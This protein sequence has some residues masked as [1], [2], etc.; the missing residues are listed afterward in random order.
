[1]LCFDLFNRF[2]NV[3]VLFLPFVTFGDLLAIGLELR[4]MFLVV[5]ASNE[6]TIQSSCN[7][8]MN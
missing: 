6:A 8:D 7:R 3:C 1:M 5:G 2:T 4:V